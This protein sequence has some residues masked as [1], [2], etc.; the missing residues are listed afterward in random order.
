M[1]G[2]AGRS[3]ERPEVLRDF[4]T[5]VAPHDDITGMALGW[6]VDGDERRARLA[7]LPSPFGDRR[8]GRRIAA[9]VRELVPAQ[10]PQKVW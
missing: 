4:G 3:S 6:L 8:G 10:V 5:M 7:D 9:A 1:P 2:R